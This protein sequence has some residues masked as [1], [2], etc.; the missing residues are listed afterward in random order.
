MWNDE[1]AQ[2][3]RKFLPFLPPAQE[4]EPDTDLREYGL[5][6]LGIV[7]L[8]AQLEQAFGVRFLDEALTLETFETP[9]VLWKT[10][11]SMRP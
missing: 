4:L 5:D 11:E 1:F 6:S 2:A 10:L 9:D 7:E 3:L 8:L